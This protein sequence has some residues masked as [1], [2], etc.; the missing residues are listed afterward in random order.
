MG[1]LARPSL[2]NPLRKEHQKRS[3]KSHICDLLS[4]RLNVLNLKFPFL[5]P[6][7]LFLRRNNFAIHLQPVWGHTMMGKNPRLNRN[8]ATLHDDNSVI[9]V[10]L[11]R[12]INRTYLNIQINEGTP[13]YNESY[14]DSIFEKN[15]NL[16]DEALIII[17]TTW[18]GVHNF[19]TMLLDDFMA[20]DAERLLI[21]I[22]TLSTALQN[23][24]PI[25]T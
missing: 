19:L 17:P 18:M 12:I 23:L 20:D 3:G 25:E 10:N 4:P 1:Y 21:G 15:V 7:C 14:C 11:W 6:C 2:H 8:Q 5:F 22:K 13:L 24:A 9:A 16:A